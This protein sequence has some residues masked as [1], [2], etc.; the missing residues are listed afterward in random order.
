[1]SQV[2]KARQE[3]TAKTDEMGVTAQAS[4]LKDVAMLVQSRVKDGEQGPQG[5]PGPKGDKGDT[6]DIN[7]IAALVP[8]GDKG[9][10]GPR[11]E[12]DRIT[13]VKLKDNKLF[14]ALNG[15]PLD[16]VG[17]VN[18]PS[19]LKGA[20]DPGGGGGGRAATEAGRMLWDGS[21]TP[22]KQ[23][24]S[25]TVVNDAGW[26]MIANKLTNDR[27]APQ[28]TGP[29]KKIFNGL[30]VDEQDTAKQVSFG[31][32]SRGAVEYFYQRVRG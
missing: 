15:G 27:A 17:E 23:V 6:H 19:V 9:D 18:M 24:K 32:E 5:E 8:A 13:D 4:T 2:L 12:A 22:N 16:M 31:V 7:A 3:K 25:Q 28:P 21:Y 10:T 30:L 14:V 11:G 26:L 20:F 1:M 29:E